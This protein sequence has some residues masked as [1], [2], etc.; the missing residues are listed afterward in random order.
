MKTILINKL[1]KH[2]FFIYFSYI[3]FKHNMIQ[4]NKIH[5]HRLVIFVF[6]GRAVKIKLGI[7]L[8]QWK[9]NKR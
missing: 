6:R 8:V 4:L 9:K 1:I 7:L 2:E 3:K 5:F